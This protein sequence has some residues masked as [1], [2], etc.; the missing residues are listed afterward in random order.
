VEKKPSREWHEEQLI[1][2]VCDKVFL[3][4]L[5]LFVS[6]VAAFSFYCLNHRISIPALAK[7]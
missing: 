4:R 7:N 1:G 2:A 6:F 3:L 5:W